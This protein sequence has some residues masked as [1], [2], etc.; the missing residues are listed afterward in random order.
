MNHR[1]DDISVAGT[2][3]L[4][5]Y[6]ELV[7]VYVKTLVWKTLRRLADRLAYVATLKDNW[8]FRVNLENYVETSKLLFGF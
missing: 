5:R 4:Y 2:D 3:K 6:S 1:S 8:W 7:D